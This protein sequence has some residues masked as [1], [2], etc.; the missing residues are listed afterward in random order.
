MNLKHRY[1]RILHW[2]AVLSFLF[3]FLFDGCGNTNEKTKTSL[4]TID[5][6]FIECNDT[7][8]LDSIPVSSNDTFTSNETSQNSNKEKSLSEIISNKIPFAKLFLIPSEGN[9]SG[10]AIVIDTMQYIKYF[11]IFLSFLFLVFGISIKYLE[12]KAIKTILLIDILALIAISIYEPPPIILMNYEKRWGF[13][14]YLIVISL[15][16]IYDLLIVKY[17]QRQKSSENGSH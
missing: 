15:I 1:S 3:P 16:T 12:A 9:R 8:N 5:T 14:F 17:H 10:L 7:A 11:G 2:I 4:D 13:W 6:T